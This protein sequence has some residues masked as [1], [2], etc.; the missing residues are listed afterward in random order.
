MLINW[1]H[2]YVWFFFFLF[3]VSVVF[4]SKWYLHCLIIIWA[5]VDAVQVNVVRCE[6]VDVIEA[7]VGGVRVVSVPLWGQF[8]NRTDRGRRE[9]KGIS[10]HVIGVVVLDRCPKLLRRG[11]AYGRDLNH[12]LPQGRQPWGSFLFLVFCSST[13]CPF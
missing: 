7:H 6:N 4:T 13:N 9:R 5:H 2:S 12:G 8:W 10:W 3:F 11:E 1:T